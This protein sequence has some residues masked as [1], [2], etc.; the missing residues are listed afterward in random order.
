MAVGERVKSTPWWPSWSVWVRKR[1]RQQRSFTVRVE[2]PK[3]AWV[4]STRADEQTIL[5]DVSAAATFGC[6]KQKARRAGKDTAGWAQGNVRWPSNSCRSSQPRKDS[7]GCTRACSQPL[8][9]PARWNPPTALKPPALRVDTYHL[10]NRSRSLLME[11]TLLSL[12]PLAEFLSGSSRRHTGRSPDPPAQE[13][14]SSRFVLSGARVIYLRP[15]S[16]G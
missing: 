6:G 12:G 5:S 9:R 11:W 15:A 7:Q 1:M 3:L 4:A 2:R 10:S 14:Q 8:R 13:W 16:Y